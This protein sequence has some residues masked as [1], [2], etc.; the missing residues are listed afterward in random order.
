LAPA[1]NATTIGSGPD[2]RPV[3]FHKVKDRT[4]RLATVIIASLDTLVFVGILFATLGSGSDAATK[5]LDNAAGVA[6]GALFL[7]TAAAALFLAARGRAPRIALALA[8]VFPA[9]I[10]GFVAVVVATLP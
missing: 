5:G 1:A 3:R 2:P 8:L 7:L 9:A 10:V 4:L 6:I